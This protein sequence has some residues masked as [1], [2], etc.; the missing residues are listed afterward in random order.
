MLETFPWFRGEGFSLIVE[1]LVRLA[2]DV[3]VIA[4]GIRLLPPR[5]AAVD[6]RNSG[7]EF[8]GRTS[9]PDRAR[10]N[11]LERDRMFTDALSEETER[12]NSG[13]TGR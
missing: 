10:R 2:A 12:L 13:L 4:E 8:L 9:D 3:G 11:L 1:D 6:T 7:W 5:V